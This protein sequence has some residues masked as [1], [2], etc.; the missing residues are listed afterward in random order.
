MK[1]LQ[2]WGVILFALV[3]I[4]ALGYRG[5]KNVVFDA[6]ET[7]STRQPVLAIVI[8]DF[9]GA[10]NHGVAELLA[11]NKPLQ[12]RLCPTWFIPLSRAKRLIK[13]DMK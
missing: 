3:L 1:K 2:R 5:L 7:V 6:T 13:E 10:D 8:D 12:W 4:A 11:L 9:G